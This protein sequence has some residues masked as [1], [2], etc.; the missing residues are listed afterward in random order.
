MVVSDEVVLSVLVVMVTYL[1]IYRKNKMVGDIFFMVTG[2][3]LLVMTGIEPVFGIMLMIGFIAFLYD[4]IGRGI[5][6]QQ[7][8]PGF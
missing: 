7:N 8:K 2:I 3:A 6:A 4:T 1:V 5:Q